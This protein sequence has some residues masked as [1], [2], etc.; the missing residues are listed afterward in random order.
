M[1]I[2]LW[3]RHH[4]CLKGNYTGNQYPNQSSSTVSDNVYLSSYLEK[5]KTAKDIFETK[6]GKFVSHCSELT[7]KRCPMADTGCDQLLPKNYLPPH[8][9]IMCARW[10]H[11]QML[12]SEIE[13]NISEV[14][15]FNQEFI[16]TDGVEE[17][18][19]IKEV[20]S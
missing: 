18:T 16:C 13:K 2:C 12:H 11:D 17:G 6:N 3:T 5:K 20:T 9:S 8:I 7:N 15:F 10:S 4:I 14:F 19:K 1:C